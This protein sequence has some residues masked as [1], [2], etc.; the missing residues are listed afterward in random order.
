MNSI[1]R[2]FVEFAE[3]RR[4]EGQLKRQLGDLEEKR[5]HHSPAELK[6]D[7]EELNNLEYKAKMFNKGLFFCME[8]IPYTVNFIPFKSFYEGRINLLK[9][10]LGYNA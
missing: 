6:K 3:S 9:A 7:V 8:K 1:A 10:N 4:I 2:F 5:L